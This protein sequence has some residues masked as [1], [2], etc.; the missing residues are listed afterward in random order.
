MDLRFDEAR[1]PRQGPIAG[2]AARV[3]W[4]LSRRPPRLP[5]TPDPPV[6]LLK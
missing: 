1:R 5:L 4:D 6:P 3:G 2:T